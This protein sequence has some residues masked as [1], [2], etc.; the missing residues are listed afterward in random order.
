MDAYSEFARVY[1]KL[2][3]DVPYDKIADIID[4]KIKV[5]NLKNNIILD[6]ACGTG[7]LTKHLSERGYEMIGADL[8]YEMLEIAREKNPDVLFLNQSMD[9]FELYGTVGAIVCCLDS[10]NYLTEDESLRKMFK[11]CNNYTEPGSLLIFDINTKYKFENVL[12]DNIYTY[13]SDDIFYVWEN[14]YSPEEKL[15][16]F[17]LNFFVKENDTYR[18]FDEIHTERMYTD[19]EITKT[20]KEC[21]FEVIEKLDDFTG[22]SAKKTS[23]R[24][25]YICKNVD[26]IQAKHIQGEKI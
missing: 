23:E 25:M 19:K 4:S 10:V 3:T 14:N 26:S 20:L 11:L 5:Q 2:M 18:R 17:Y 24:V 8:S 1:D 21:G 15:C 7:T 9:D 12:A 22:N 6:L 16:D 13:D